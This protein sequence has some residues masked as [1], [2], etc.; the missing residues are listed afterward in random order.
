MYLIYGDGEEVGGMWVEKVFQFY[1][2]I[3]INYGL[4]MV[5]FLGSGKS[6]VW[7]VLL[8]VLERFEGVEGV[9]YIID[10]KVISK[11]YFYGILDFNIR[12]WIDGF[13]IYVLRKII[14]SVRGEL[15]KCQWIVFDG[16]VDL[17]WVEN[18]NLVLD[19]NKFL[20]L[21]NGECFSFL[22]NVRI[23]FEVQDLKYVIL[24]IVLCCGMVWFSED[25]LSIDMIF[26]NFLVRLCSILLD[27][28]EDEVQWWC[29]GK[30]DEGEEVVFF[31]LQI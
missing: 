6:M 19:D 5:G 8:K 25:V 20:I 23:M 27:E 1:Q 17:E 7:C 11:D 14:D 9:V 30:E 15:Q 13:F 4:M 26:N 22:F 29:K 2:I 21:F 31:M 18:L 12:E 24:V 16:D 10:F 28:G 3:Q